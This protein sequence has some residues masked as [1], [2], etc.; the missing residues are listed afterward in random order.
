MY[1]GIRSQCGKSVRREISLHFQ[2]HRCH[3]KNSARC[4]PQTQCYLALPAAGTAAKGPTNP[5]V[6]SVTWNPTGTDMK[7]KPVSPEDEVYVSEDCHLRWTHRH[8]GYLWIKC[9]QQGQIQP[10]SEG[11]QNKGQQTTLNDQTTFPR[12]QSDCD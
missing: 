6:D 10:F 3:K 2:L 11:D 12:M 5:G 8:D 4:F 1:R 9:L 7:Q